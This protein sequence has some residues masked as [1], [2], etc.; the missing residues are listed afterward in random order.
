M[1]EAEQAKGLLLQA[2]AL[3]AQANSLLRLC[4]DDDRRRVGLHWQY[5]WIACGDPRGGQGTKPIFDSLTPDTSRTR[6]Q[7][8]AF[9][10]QNQN[11]HYRAEMRERMRKKRMP[12]PMI[13]ERWPA[14]GEVEE[15]ERLDRENVWYE[16][17]S[18]V[19]REP[20]AAPVDPWQAFLQKIARRE[21]KETGRPTPLLLQDSAFIERTRTYW[22]TI[23]NLEL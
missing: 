11:P 12:E 9:Y 5:L 8:G 1:A 15:K 19:R 7:V 4:T 20:T 23:Q 13:W 6:A 17:F 14:R 3:I 18:R 16:R 2:E 21:S 10:S 22:N